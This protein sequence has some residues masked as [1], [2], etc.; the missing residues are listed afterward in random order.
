MKEKNGMID[1]N[2]KR[3]FKINGK[4]YHSIEEMPDHIKEAFKK[5]MA[6]RTDSWYQ[7][8][9]AA[10]RTKTIFNGREYESLD[11]MPQDVRQLYEKVLQATETGDASPVISQ[12]SAVW[13]EPGSHVNVYLEG[14]PKHTKFESSFSLRSLIVTAGIAVI[15]LLFYYLWKSR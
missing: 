2:I 11:A 3:E 7:T 10:A 14:I 8:G 15:L 5:A 9:P 4:V 6:L 12:H 13:K 1:I